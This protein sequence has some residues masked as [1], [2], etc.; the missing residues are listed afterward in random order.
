M[1]QIY[2]LLSGLLLAICVIACYDDKG[3]YDYNWIQDIDLTDVLKDTTIK[4]GNVLH[5]AV[6]LQKEILGSEDETEN[7]N[8]E[9]YAY[10]WL[11]L[12]NGSIYESLIGFIF[13]KH[14]K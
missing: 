7:A 4:R 10:E 11:V 14:M 3:N 1:K 6:D 12:E 2:K 8:P 13:R 5:I 9:D